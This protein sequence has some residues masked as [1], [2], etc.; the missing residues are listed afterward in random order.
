MIFLSYVSLPEGKRKIREP[1]METIDVHWDLRRFFCEFSIGQY[2]RT[3]K[4]LGRIM[5]VAPPANLS[6]GM[7]HIW[8]NINKNHATVWKA[9][10][11]Q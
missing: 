2:T 7:G 4:S 5:L 3:G 11:K 1:H 10:A 9:V 8:I 6:S